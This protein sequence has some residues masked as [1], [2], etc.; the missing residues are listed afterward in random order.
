[1]VGGSSTFQK[2]VLVFVVATGLTLTLQAAEP[3]ADP[4]KEAQSL[5]KLGDD[6]ASRDEVRAASDAY[7]QALSLARNHFSPDECVR[8]AVILSW[9]DRLSAAIRELRLVLERDPE[10]R[11][12]RIHLARIYSWD[13]QLTRAVSIADSLLSDSPDDK[14]TLLVKA[15]ALEWDDRFNDAIPVYEGIIRRDGDFDARVGLAS[16]LLYNGNRAEAQRQAQTLVATDARQRRQLE[17]LSDSIDREMKPRMEIGYDYYSDSDENHYGR[18]SA[19][20]SL[21][22]GNHDFAVNLGRTG[23]GDTTSA[24][25]LTFHADINASAVLGF[26]GGIGVTRLHSTDDAQF[27][28]GYLRLHGHSRKTL[29][30]ATMSSE[31]L[32]ETSQLIANHI[33]RL[34]AGGEI[35]QKFTASWSVS[36]AYN[37][38]RFSD[39]N[40]ANDAQLRA[41]YT[42]RQA[43]RVGLAYQLRF[44]DYDRQSANGYFDP[45]NFLSHRFSASINVERRSYFTFVQ[46]YGGHQ[47]F[48]RFGYRTSEWV[49]GVRGSFGFNISKDAAISVNIAAGD[50]S[51]GSVT[52][53][54]YFTA[55]TRLSYRF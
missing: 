19:R 53:Y 31:V 43:P 7:E 28:T 21:A 13:G 3:Q 16:S 30:R 14:E 46:V 1:M 52:G 25:D 17:R 33:R 44:L 9:D 12:A 32:A 47:R 4:V 22:A 15:N 34:S 2:I 51:T 38:M 45:D 40:Q 49:K 18:Y 29:F 54:G 26:A 36:G 42:T 10:N 35:T 48:E 50:S 39:V 27:P 20:Y 23:A 37:R 55:G 8:M 5:K 24:D 6:Y 11:N 41:E